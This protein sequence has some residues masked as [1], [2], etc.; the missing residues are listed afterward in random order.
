MAGSARSMGP[1]D[2]THRLPD[3]SSADELADLSRAFND[4]LDRLTEAFERERRF[5]GE[6]S[7]QLRTPLAALIGQVEVGAAAATANRTSTG[8]ALASVLGSGGPT[9]PRGG[10]SLV[11]GA[12]GSGTPGSP[13]LERIDL[14]AWVPGRHLRV[15]DDHPAQWRSDPGAVAHGSVGDRAPGPVGR[16]AR[17]AS[18]QRAEVQRAG[19]AGRGSDRARFR[20]RVG[21]GRGP[22]L[23]D[24]AGGSSAPVPTVLPI[25]CGTEAR[26]WRV[27]GLGL[28]VA[29]RIASAL[30]GSITVESEPD[31]GCLMR[32]RLPLTAPRENQV[33]PSPK[34]PG[35]LGRT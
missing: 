23:R 30:G 6:A 33:A 10:G 18:G 13:G 8:R 27:R 5:A 14:G 16:T 26:G 3:S 20:V 21:R 7:H 19:H 32:V 34:G 9:A 24:R 1:T 4:L 12:L 25:G 11:P 35:L 17:C 29:A 2:L 28:A 22:G 15:W 31:R